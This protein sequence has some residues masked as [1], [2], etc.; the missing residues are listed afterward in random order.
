[1]NVPITQHPTCVAVGREPQAESSLLS[2]DPTAHSD[3]FHDLRLISKF[4]VFLAVKW[5]HWHYLP[6]HKVVQG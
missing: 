1:M 3:L 6:L 5:Y 2:Y 4:A